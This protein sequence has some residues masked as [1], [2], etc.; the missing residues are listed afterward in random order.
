VPYD[1]I[2]IEKEVENFNDDLSNIRKFISDIEKPFQY[3]CIS[4][5]TN[6][7]VEAYNRIQYPTKKK[8]APAGEVYTFIDQYLRV[9]ESSRK[10]GSLQEYRS[11]KSHLLSRTYMNLLFCFC[12]IF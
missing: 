5:D 8:E 1:K 12:L 2:P 7:I 3:N 11:S 10:P 6:M 4:Y 9:N